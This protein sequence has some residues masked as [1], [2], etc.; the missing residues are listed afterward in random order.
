MEAAEPLT[1]PAHR[2]RE[3]F[4]APLREVLEQ[5]AHVLDLLHRTWQAEEARRRPEALRYCGWRCRVTASTA[6]RW[7]QRHDG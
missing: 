2:Q 1:P 5:T 6:A 4:A 7:T 3:A